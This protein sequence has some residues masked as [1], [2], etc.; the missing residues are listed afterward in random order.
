MPL[1][2]YGLSSSF[3]G[4]SGCRWL[5]S[6]NNGVVSGLIDPRIT[7]NSNLIRNFTY[8]CNGTHVVNYQTYNYFTGTYFPNSMNETADNAQLSAY[9][10][11]GCKVVSLWCGY[12]DAYRT[13]LVNQRTLFP[14]FSVSKTIYMVLLGIAQMD[15]YFDWDDNFASL[16]PGFQ[17]TTATVSDI[18]GDYVIYKEKKLI[19]F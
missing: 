10:P 13:V 2:N 7:A 12:S 3:D 5:N 15:D 8:M 17:I 4:N 16:M 1:D 6:F 18:F 11:D 9:G 14:V 19:Y